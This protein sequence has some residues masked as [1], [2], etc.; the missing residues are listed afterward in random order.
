MSLSVG[1]KGYTQTLLVCY[2]NISNAAHIPRL[3][4]RSSQRLSRSN[5]SF[6][7]VRPHRPLIAHP[8][9]PTIF[10]ILTR[11]F[12]WTDALPVGLIGMN[13][14]LM[15]QYIEFV[16]DHL[17]QSLGCPKHYHSANPFEWMD[18]ISMQGKTNFFEKRVAE[19]S[20]A[21]LSRSVSRTG[22]P[23]DPLGTPS[24]NL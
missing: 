23:V 18:M 5:R 10:R 24:R 9:I 1:T 20:K 21:H 17:L 3:S 11:F 16:A 8:Y 14:A 12:S 6:C 4:V 7:Q 2:Y 19:Y 22:T 13:A 15:C